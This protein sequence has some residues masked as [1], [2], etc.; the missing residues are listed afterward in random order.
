MKRFFSLAVALLLLLALISCG[1]GGD[2]S[3]STSGTSP[4]TTA[5]ETTTGELVHVT[6][7]RPPY[8]S[9]LPYEYEE[10]NR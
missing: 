8:D 7:T 4:E 6:E 9:W 2:A 10:D 5:E 1:D 3:E